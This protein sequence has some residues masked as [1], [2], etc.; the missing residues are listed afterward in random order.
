MSGKIFQGSSS[1]KINGNSEIHKLKG[2]N[3]LDE[4]I[5]LSTRFFLLFSVNKYTKLL[6]RGCTCIQLV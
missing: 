6:S 5:L 3:Y 1:R 4:R 2:K